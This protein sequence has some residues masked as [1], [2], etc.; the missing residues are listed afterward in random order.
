[1]TENVSLSGF[2]CNCTADLPANSIAETYMTGP[3]GDYVGKVKIV[4]S[5][6]MAAPLRHYTCRFVE[7][8]GPWVLQ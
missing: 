5:N 1:M 8:V 2:L 3:T 6:A 7:K 4:Y